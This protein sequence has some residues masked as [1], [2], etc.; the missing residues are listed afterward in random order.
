M[1]IEEEEFLTRLRAGEELAYRE[2]V[3]ACQGGMRAVARAIAGPASPTRS[4]RTPGW[5]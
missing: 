4:S 5:P 3:G 1:S 2:L